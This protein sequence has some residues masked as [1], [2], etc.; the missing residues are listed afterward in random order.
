[1]SFKKNLE[2]DLKVAQ[3]SNTDAH[4]STSA[5]LNDKKKLYLKQRMIFE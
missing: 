5:P 1:M 2:H 3:I 4:K